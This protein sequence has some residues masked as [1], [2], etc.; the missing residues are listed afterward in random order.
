MKKVLALVLVVVLMLALGTTAFA[1]KPSGPVVLKLSHSHNEESQYQAAALAIKEYVEEKTEGAVQIDI[2]PN[3]TLGDEVEGLDG[4][5]L[6]TVDLLMIAPGNMAERS[7]I[8]NLFSLPYMFESEQHAENVMFGDL[9]KEI[10]AQV[11]KDIGITCFTYGQV[12][13]RNTMNNLRSIYTPADLKGVKLRVPNIAPIISAF[14]AF[15]AVPITSAFSEVYTSI[16]AGMMNGLENP[17]SVLTSDKFY[18]VCN[19]LTLTEHVYDPSIYCGSNA[20]MQKLTE[21]QQQILRE[22]MEIGAKL[23]FEIVAE[24]QAN[25]ISIM[26]ENG[27]TV[28]EVTDKSEW[29]ELVA[30]IYDQY[31]DVL[32]ADFIAQIKS[33]K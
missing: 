31:S 3:S 32:S 23:S 13:F 11:E 18:E 12:G 7:P 30:P 19:Y 27:V 24:E 5:I 16:S 28:N 29:A 17:L 22:A 1:A 2:Y 15:G 8:L 10:L 21:E 26:E 33:Y 25:Y 6:G 4:L 20:A 9:G 14:D